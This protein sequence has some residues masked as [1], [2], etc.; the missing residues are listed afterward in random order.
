MALSGLSIV[1]LYINN[2]SGPK[3]KDFARREQTLRGKVVRVL[4]E[5]VKKA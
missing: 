2:S 5:V 4:E 1:V 3:P